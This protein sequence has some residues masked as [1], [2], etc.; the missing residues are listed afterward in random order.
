MAS[1]QKLKRGAEM[2]TTMPFA[3][4]GE[5]IVAKDHVKLVFYGYQ[6]R[7]KAVIHRHTTAP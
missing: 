7:E 3:K 1:N 5:V 2:E 6:Q 4:L